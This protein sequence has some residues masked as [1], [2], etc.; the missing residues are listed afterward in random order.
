MN[1]TVERL[2]TVGVF[3]FALGLVSSAN[4]AINGASL[5]LSTSTAPNSPGVLTGPSIEERYG[6]E[7]IAAVT[8][9]L[10]DSR[11]YAWASA[12]LTDGLPLLKAY[13]E[14]KTGT[15]AARG[16]PSALA[17]FQYSGPDGA[18][19]TLTFTLTG[20][21]SRPDPTRA[22]V[23]GDVFLLSEDVPRYEPFTP[24]YFESAT[25]LESAAI[26]DPQGSED[27]SET[28]I[29]QTELMDGDIFHV[30]MAL[31]AFAS[32]APAYA[33]AT[34]TLSG[35]IEVSAGSVTAIPEPAT[36]FLLLAGAAGF[37]RTRRG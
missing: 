23:Q 16:N 4:A 27:V 17:A 13:A 31:S 11:G 32:W 33:D 9:S 21:V 7:G 1:R 35:T 12:L 36:M 19:L 37:Q 15:T 18:D 8:Q 14:P 22:F 24:N 2:V 26:F 30:A 6:G 3:A 28:L 20:E 29:L 34:S 5:R 10:D 25:V